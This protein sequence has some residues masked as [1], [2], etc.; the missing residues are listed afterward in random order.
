MQAAIGARE[1]WT[2]AAGPQPKEM[3]A[4]ALSPEKTEKTLGWVSRLDAR[5]TI[6]WTAD[7]YKSFAKGDDAQATTLAQIAR[8]IGT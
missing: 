2:Q 5:A 8:Y 7:W 3:P 4:L 6:D 1:G